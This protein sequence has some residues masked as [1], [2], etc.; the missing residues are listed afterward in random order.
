MY[1]VGSVVVDDEF[2]RKNHGS[3]PATAIEKG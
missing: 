1:L 2:G 3:I